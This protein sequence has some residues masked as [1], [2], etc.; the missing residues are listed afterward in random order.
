MKTLTPPWSSDNG[1]PA[2]I[3]PL[4]PGDRLGVEEFERRYEAMPEV[5]K[6]E[7]IE[8]VVYMPSP[9]SIQKHGR[10]H[11]RFNWWLISY[12]IATTGVEVGDNSTLKEL[13]GEN[14]PQ[15][16]SLLRIMSE[17]GG[18]SGT[19]QKGYVAG[20]PELVGEIAASTASYDLHDKLEVFRRNRVLEYIVWRVE[21]REIDWFYLSGEKYEKIQPVDGMLRS[22]VFPGLWL[23]ASALIRG[24]LQR[25]LEVL[26]IG[27][28]SPEH[29]AFVA[30][31][32][33]QKVSSA[34]S[35]A[36]RPNPSGT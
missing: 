9:V 2:E 26:Q 29:A 15:P 5:K 19:D 32:Q 16:D 6:A 1:Q 36:D 4:H 20:S 14:E 17:F 21:D 34:A 35:S 28:A 25:V 31:L 8:G 12:E 23:D 27:V 13:E 3:P 24:D 22:R 11:S 18:Q 7:L 10:P 30:K 33:S